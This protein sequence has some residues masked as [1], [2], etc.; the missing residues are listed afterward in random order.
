MMVEASTVSSARIR[1]PALLL[2]AA[3]MVAL[4]GLP[5]HAQAPSPAFKPITLALDF[6][7]LGRFAP[8]YVA[9]GKNYYREAGLDVTIVPS[10]GT[11]QAV[12]ALEGGIAQFAVS[13]LAGLVVGRSQGTSTAKMIAVVYQKSPYAIY[14][15]T[16]GANVT[17]PEQ[18]EGLEIAS[19]A[20]SAT[21]KIIVGFMRNKGL[22]T[23]KVRFTNIDGAARV[24][25]LLSNRVPAIETFI[26]AKPGI[27]RSAGIGKVT[28]FLLA[29]HGLD[30]YSSGLLVT[31]AYLKNNADVAK[32]FVKASMMGWRDAVA[33]PREAAKLM[34]D[35]VKAL[36]PDVV[37]SELEIVRDLAVTPDVKAK[38]FGTIDRDRFVAGVD[39]LAR[40]V[41][42]AGST[43]AVNAMLSMEYLPQPPVLPK[44]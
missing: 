37:V 10:Q 26:L 4:P 1:L 6:I 39:F 40:N 36:Q 44:D 15:L 24:S 9:L 14:S 12:Q 29:D 19:G 21:P 38:G 43:P 34:T 7:V 18:L 5:V 32:A 31:E 2:G 13:D 8:W 28:T 17:R 33:D 30:L 23:S 20:G 3:I 16:S 35:Q 41:E 42:I 27:E 22:D 11:A 25:M